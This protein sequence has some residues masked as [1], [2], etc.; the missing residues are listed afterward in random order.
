MLPRGTID[1]TIHELMPGGQL[2]E[3][4]K[5][6][7]GAWGGTEVDEAYKQFIISLIGNPIFQRFCKEHK[8]DHI[9]MFRDFEI[10]KRSV[11]PENDSDVIIRLPFSLKETYQKICDQ[12]LCNSIKQTRYAKEVSLVGDKLRIHASV[13]K[14]FFAK[15]IENTI[16]HVKDLM[17]NDLVQTISGI[18]MVGGY[19]ESKMLQNAIKDNFPNVKVI[20][21]YEASLVVL[22]G[23]VIFGHTPTAIAQRV[24]R[25]T[26]GFNTSVPFDPRIHDRNKLIYTDDGLKCT[27]IFQKHVEIG[28]AIIQGQPQILGGSYWPTFNY[29]TDISFEIYCSDKKSPMYITDEGCIKLGQ[30]TVLVLDMSVPI[31]QREFVLSMS[32]SG[33]EIEVSAK[34]KR[35]GRCTKT[36]VNFLG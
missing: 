17:K 8:D 35:T 18:L 4:Y 36:T 28:Q 33:T 31:Y 30:I 26:Y 9:H 13:I 32:F 3:L 22:K 15:S 2:K 12:D 21:P 19:S 7:G 23:A 25:Y 14:G 29:Q 5:A 16:S 34:E 20:V 10:K 24:C 1:I 27:D 6:T 11:N